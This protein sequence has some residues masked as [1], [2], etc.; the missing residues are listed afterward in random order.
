VHD[1]PGWVED[2]RG[3]LLLIVWTVLIIRIPAAWRPRQRPAWMVL[4]AL[5]GGSV[6]IQAEVAQWINR[7][8]GVARASDLVVA[9]V[10]LVDFAAVWWFALDLH[11]AAGAVRNRWQRAPLIAAGTMAL[12]AI[13]FFVVTPAA[14]RFGEQ[15]H[16]WWFGYALAWIG[17]GA[18]TAVGAATIF[19][20]HGWAMRSMVL[21]VSLLALALGTAAELPYLAIRAVRWSVPDAPSALVLIGFWCSFTRFVVVA[22]ACSLATLE[23]LRRAALYRLRRQRLY[24]LWLLLRTAT[25]DLVLQPPRA[26]VVDLMASGSSW[27]LLHQRV[28]DIRD[29]VASLRDGWATQQLLDDAARYSAALGRPDRERTVAVACWIETA[30]RAALA[31]EPKLHQE[32][33]GSLLLDVY[34]SES[35][36]RREVSQL[37]R[38]FRC[39]RSGTVRSFADGRQRPASTSRDLG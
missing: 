7:V 10:A 19:W 33:D 23:P 27:E 18:T 11:R 28:V 34:A 6:V 24:R 5:A 39:L 9:L 29:S 31:G 30:R 15:A 20:R 21:R 3:V 36:V 26:P 14:D 17:Y 35:T 2:L 37:L 13:G 22:L 1:V 32:L 8:S 4:V 16:G 38:L 25:P 12:L